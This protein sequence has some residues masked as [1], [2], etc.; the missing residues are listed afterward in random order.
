MAVDLAPSS[1]QF[2]LVSLLELGF[3]IIPL[4]VLRFGFKKDIRQE[5]RDRLFP[6][7]RSIVRRLLDLGIG[8]IVGILFVPFGSLISRFTYQL[9]VHYMGVEYYVQA[10]EGAVNVTPPSLTIFELVI[11]IVI[12][13][14]LVALSEEF[15][16]RGVI[17]REIARKSPF[18]GIFI[19]SFLFAIYHVLPGIVPIRTFFVFWP[20]FFVFGLILALVTYLQKGDLLSAIVAHGIFNSILFYLQFA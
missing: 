14:L 12:M 17:Y 16:F 9:T 13:F 15:C 8:L 19:S 6:S 18:L 1:I 7:P 10:V 3:I 4:L 5:F 2:F 11:S 20:Y